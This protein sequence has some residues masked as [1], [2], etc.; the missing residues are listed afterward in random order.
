[1]SLI[2]PLT[3]ELASVFTYTYVTANHTK[4]KNQVYKKN[5]NGEFSK[6]NSEKTVFDAYCFNKSYTTFR[7]KYPTI[8]HIYGIKKQKKFQKKVICCKSFQ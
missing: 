1:M 8:I 3:C 2:D 6:R 7:N 5:V 4:T